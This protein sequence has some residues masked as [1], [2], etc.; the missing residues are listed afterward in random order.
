MHIILHNIIIIIIIIIIITF[1][2]TSPVMESFFLCVSI[3]VKTAC[4]L[5]LVSFMLVAATVLLNKINN[6]NN[7]FFNFLA[8]ATESLFTNTHTHTK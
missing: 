5:L 8:E 4:D 7:L 6:Y 3:I 1:S 2:A